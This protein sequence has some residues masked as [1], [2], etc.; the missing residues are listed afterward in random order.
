MI[1]VTGA[2]GFLGA[3]LV[4]QLTRSGTYVKALKREHSTIPS[5]IASNNAIE[6]INA[7]INDVANLEDV[8]SGITQVYHC[9][10]LVSFRPADKSRLFRINIEGT[11]NI[12]NLCLQNGVRLLHVSSVAALGDSKSG[13]MITEEDFWE[14][15]TK[16]HAYAE[17]KYEAEME[18]WRG[19][20]EGLDAV[21]V[22]PSVIIGGG[23]GFNGSGQLFKLIKDGFSFYTRGAT[24]LVDVEDVARIMI[25]AMQSNH[26][27]ERYI[28]S[29]ENYLYQNLFKEIADGFGVK[30]PT[31]EA[32]PWMMKVGWM[33]GKFRSLLS[34]K[35]SSLTRD[36]IKS[37]ITKSYYD[38]DKARKTFNIT[39]KPLSQSI[40]E[41]CSA[42]QFK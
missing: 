1:L 3:E 10:A 33:L 15:G 19:I 7:D 35:S 2:T 22:N 32:K 6:W 13:K 34:G 24:G 4:H 23:T 29:A 39:F 38:N 11:A 14:Y 37:S 27:A 28:I 30:P 5:L 26:T 40:A 16:T 9:A 25:L 42:L 31:I 36:A 18:V 20:A 21:I 12:V 8:F 17:S 41:T